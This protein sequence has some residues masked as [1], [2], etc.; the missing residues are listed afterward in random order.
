LAVHIGDA[1]AED[2]LE[3]AG[4]REAAIGVISVPDPRAAAAITRTVRQLA[5]RAALIVRCRYQRTRS[6]LERAGADIVVDEEF[7]VGQRLAQAVTDRL[8]EDQLPAMACVFTGHD[9]G[10]Q[11]AE[12]ATKGD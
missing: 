11:T 8:Y 2:F 3:H 9:A 7:M 6:D 5:P 12:R 1:T 10:R 4:V